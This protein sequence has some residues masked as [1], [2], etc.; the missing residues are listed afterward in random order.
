M[1][2]RSLL[3]AYLTNSFKWL[4]FSYEYLYNSLIPETI[5]GKGVKNKA[6]VS[7]IYANGVSENQF[8]PLPNTTDFIVDNVSQSISDETIT[9]TIPASGVSNIARASFNVVNVYAGHK[10]LITYKIKIGSV[11]PSTEIRI[12]SQHDVFSNPTAILSNIQANTNYNCSYILNCV[13]SYTNEKVRY[14][15]FQGTKY[16]NGTCDVKD[17]MFIDLTLMFGTGNEPTTL[18]DNRIQ[19]ILNRGYIAYNTGTYKGTDIS[20]FSSEPYNLFDGEIEGNII[21]NQGQNSSGGQ[22]C[23]SKNYI[24]VIGGRTY[25]FSADGITLAS[26][27]YLIICEYDEN[28]NFIQGTFNSYTTIPHT[29]I[30]SN[31]THYIRWALRVG[32]SGWGTNPPTQ[33]TV[34]VCFHLTG[35]RTGYATHQT[36][37]PLSFIYQ[38]NGALNSHD[39]FEI[40]SSEYVITKNNSQEYDL[41]NFAVAVGDAGT[42]HERAFIYGSTLA[43]QKTV[44]SSEIA[45]IVCD[46]YLTIKMNEVYNHSKEGI[47]GGIIAGTNGYLY[48]YDTTLIGKTAQEIKTAI[49]GKKIRF[50]LATP[51]V[52]RIPKKHLGI[53][54]IR[55][56]TGW[57]YSTTT[58]RFST[59]ISNAKP[60]A[61]N[62]LVANI[63]CSPFLAKTYA[64][65]LSDNLS[66]AIDMVSYCYIRDTSIN[67]I[68]D[69]LNKYGDYYIFYETENEVSD[70]ADTISIEKGGTITSNS[71][72]LPNVDFNIKCK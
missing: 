4:P 59:L 33:D 52:I 38:G 10:Y 48:L 21:D 71:Q 14:V 65:S 47:S 42:S 61:H 13:T 31:N 72:V 23:R 60:T 17:I 2:R 53:V 1:S 46:S 63:Y 50:E 15:Y 58:N 32:G 11:I 40:T 69:F 22:S 68:S 62:D 37:S 43:Q 20:E 51:Q 49:T 28:Q 55:D 70:I 39:T 34:K 44:S 54:K 8:L 25:T 3:L 29:L 24:K 9:L 19:A 6:K 7:K 66:I 45:N 41:G 18:T 57:A 26:G 27:D 30:L 5:S 35:T 67:T 64:Q 16:E 36:F 12:T 56:L